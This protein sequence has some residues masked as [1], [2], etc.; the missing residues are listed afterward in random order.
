MR[1]IR[2]LGLAAHGLKADCTVSLAQH[3]HFA[4]GNAVSANFRRVRRWSG[5][6]GWTELI[7]EASPSDFKRR[8]ATQA[9]APV[10]WTEVHGYPHWNAPR[11]SGTAAPEWAKKNSLVRRQGGPASERHF[12]GLNLMSGR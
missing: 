1:A 5:A 6:R 9:A 10:P 11:P 12:S 2:F 7:S 4:S 3:V 8:S